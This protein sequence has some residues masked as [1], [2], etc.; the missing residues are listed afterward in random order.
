MRLIG[1]ASLVVFVFAL[2]GCSVRMQNL[3][4]AAEEAL[5]GNDDVVL[6]EA[7]IADLPY[8]AAYFDTETSGRIVAV[9]DRA[10]EL[11]RVYRTGGEEAFVT[12]FGRV[13]SS[14]NMPG[15]PL[16]TSD[17]ASDPLSCWVRQTA[18]Q[19]TESNCHNSWQRTV[20]LG[21]Y[22]SNVLRQIKVSS[23]FEVAAQQTYR[24][25]DGTELQATKIVERG[26]FAGENFSNEF[27]AVN[28]RVVFAKHYLSKDLGYGILQEIKPFN[29]DL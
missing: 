16:Y 4:G 25:P 10:T 20:E 2:S 26:V 17:W 13:I 29:G 15:V 19:H 21:N 5:F 11:Q 9:L 7:E 27:Y 28:G 24:H 1:F 18:A 6:T 14:S 3:A 8:A 23:T 12:R 22:G